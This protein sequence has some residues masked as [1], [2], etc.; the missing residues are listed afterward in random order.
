MSFEI[1][2]MQLIEQKFENISLFT[3]Q[4]NRKIG[5]FSTLCRTQDGLHIMKI[6]NPLAFHA[7]SD[8]TKVT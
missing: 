8:Q 5:H 1:R 3:F 2:Q 6:K 4:Y 7:V